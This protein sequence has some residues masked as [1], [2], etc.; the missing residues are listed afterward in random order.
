MRPAVDI[1]YL[2]QVDGGGYVDDHTRTAG[3]TELWDQQKATASG[4][5]QARRALLDIA[6]SL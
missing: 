4:P 1:I 3:Y 6:K 5:E 2:E